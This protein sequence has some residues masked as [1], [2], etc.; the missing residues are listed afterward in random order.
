MGTEIAAREFRPKQVLRL[1]VVTAIATI[2]VLCETSVSLGTAIV[3]GLLAWATF[4]GAGTAL[5]A[6]L[7]AAMLLFDDK[8]RATD[9][10]DRVNRGLG[11]GFL[12]GVCVGLLMLI[13][14]IARMA[15]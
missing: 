1:E 6:G 12:I 9:R 7:P 5:E 14:F 4:L 2:H 13:V 8:T 10:A 15:T 3:N 11:V